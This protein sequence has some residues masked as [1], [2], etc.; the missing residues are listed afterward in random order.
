MYQYPYK[1]FKFNRLFIC[2]NI[3]CQPVFN[4]PSRRIKM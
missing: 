2:I 1:T 4:K 3:F